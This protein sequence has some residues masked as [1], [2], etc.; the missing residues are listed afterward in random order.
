M[1]RPLV[2]L[3]AGGTGGHM[4]PAEALARAL[5]RRGVAIALITDKR[6][7]SFALPGVDLTVHRVRAAAMAGAS[8]AAAIA[9]LIATPELEIAA[10]VLTWQLL[11]PELAMGRVVMAA[12]LA[13]GVGMMLALT[14]R[15]VG[16]G[17]VL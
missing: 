3:A 6:G 5:A 8:I 1:T 14:R 4:F 16:Q 13:L 2:V 17:A 7:Q 11:G 12:L 10:V 9:F 15:R